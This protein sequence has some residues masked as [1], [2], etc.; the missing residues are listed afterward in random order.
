MADDGSGTGRE[1]Q[2]TLRSQRT[3]GDVRHL[4]AT[5]TADGGITIEGQDLGRGVEEAYGEGLTEYEWVWAVAPADVTA[6]V[7]ALGGEPGD[8]PLAV[9]AAWM[10]G[11]GGLDPGIALREA[12]V[13]VEFWSRIG[14]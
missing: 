5:L 8:D 7:A 14:D 12:A 10:E 3:P 4:W 2:V 6:A 9:L 1:R 13:P 11:H